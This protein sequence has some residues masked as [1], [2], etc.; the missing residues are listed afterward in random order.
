VHLY[1]GARDE[2]A[3]RKGRLSGEEGVHVAGDG[4]GVRRQWLNHSVNAG[5]Y[6]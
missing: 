6:E 2:K 1:A 4:E 5:Q 3:N